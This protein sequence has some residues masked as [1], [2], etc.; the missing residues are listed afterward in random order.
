MLPGQ[1]LGKEEVGWILNV[2]LRRK[3]W[4]RGGRGKG[5]W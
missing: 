1:G 3:D 2:M 5:D 4:G